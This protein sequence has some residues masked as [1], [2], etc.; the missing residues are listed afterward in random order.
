MQRTIQGHTKGL[1]LDD[2]DIDKC[3]DDDIEGEID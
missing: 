2:D 1:A 3:E